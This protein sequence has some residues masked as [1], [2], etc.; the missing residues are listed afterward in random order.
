MTQE[1]PEALATAAGVPSGAEQAAKA[2][3]TAVTGAQQATTAPVETATNAVDNVASTVVNPPPQKS[4]RRKKSGI[5][6]E[7]EDANTFST[8]AT[9]V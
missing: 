5:I 4:R 2:K 3:K 6:G 9:G 8:Q 7:D 1:F